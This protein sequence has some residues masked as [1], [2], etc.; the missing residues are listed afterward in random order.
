MSQAKDIR[1]HL[2]AI[3]EMQR[4]SDRTPG[5]TSPNMCIAA[6]RFMVAKL[7][8]LVPPSSHLNGFLHSPQAPAL[9]L[10]E[11]KALWGSPRHAF[12]SDLVARFNQI[13][14][15]ALL[16]WGGQRPGAQVQFVVNRR[17]SPY[18]GDRL[19]AQGVPMLIGVHLRHGRS[20]QGANSHYVTVLRDGGSNTW[21]IDSWGSELEACVRCIRART[22]FS[23]SLPIQLEL[24]S[25]TAVLPGGNLTYGWYEQDGTTLTNVLSL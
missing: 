23:L 6:S 3:R 1:A 15:P 13:V 19:L 25:G 7:A 20:V 18:Q 12:D 11:H 17:G 9:P 16:R 24:A 10:V 14:L 5:A 22:A 2:G 8:G 21:V 4:W